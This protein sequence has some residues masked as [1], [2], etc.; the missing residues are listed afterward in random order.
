M[1][2]ASAQEQNN[3]KQEIEKRRE[4]TMGKAQVQMTAPSDSAERKS[5]LV[6]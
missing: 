3:Y 4:G 2:A 6:A 5:E 1:S